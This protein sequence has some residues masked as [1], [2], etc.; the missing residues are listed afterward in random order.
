MIE[1]NKIPAFG[2]AGNF[3]GHLEQAGEAKDF[4][5][6][7][8][9]DKKAPKAIFP[10]FIPANKDESKKYNVPD[11]LLTFPFD[12]KKIIFPQN[13]K[14]IQIEP[15]CGIIFSVKYEEN[16]VVGISP[17][18]FA[19]SNDCSIRKE[20]AKKIS[21][22]KNWG[23][24]TKGFSD[25]WIAAQE[26][27]EGCIL[28]RYR[29]AS[30]VKRN[31]EIFEYGENSSVKD[32]SYFYETLIEWIIERFNNQQNEGPAEKIGDYL[33]AAGLPEKIMISIGATRYTDFGEHNYLNKGD[34]TFVILYPSDKYSYND[35]IKKVQEEIFTED[36]ISALVQE[37]V[38]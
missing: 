5:N 31:N 32:Y 23:K 18:Y 29:I 20:G 8:T 33:I 6:V 21:E 25:T 14:N 13:E 2:I 7:Q 34:K 22:K 1:M 30:F 15:E 26:L 11:Y 36:D 24:S 12:S 37:V 35:I 9:K 38:L 4:E 28:D 27:K 3:T 16:R 17:E 10:T 19:A